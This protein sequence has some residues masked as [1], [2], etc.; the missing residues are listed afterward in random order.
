MARHVVRLQFII[1]PASARPSWWWRNSSS[2]QWA[3]I[4]RTVLR[5]FVHRVIHE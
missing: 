4:N 3:S 5:T 1:P 2:Q